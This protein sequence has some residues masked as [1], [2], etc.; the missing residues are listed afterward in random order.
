MNSLQNDLGMK[1]GFCS[2]SN[3]KLDKIVKNHV[4]KLNS[5]DNYQNCIF[6]SIEFF[7][8]GNEKVNDVKTSVTSFDHM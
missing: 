8:L 2:T 5:E 6:D 7:I 3:E 4:K 1:K